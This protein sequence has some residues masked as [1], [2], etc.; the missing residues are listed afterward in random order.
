MNVTIITKLT[1]DGGRLTIPPVLGLRGG[2]L[3]GRRLLAEP[4]PSAVFGQKW[5]LEEP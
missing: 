2:F 5:T 4:D 3:D 1:Q